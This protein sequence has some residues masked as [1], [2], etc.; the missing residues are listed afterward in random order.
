VVTCWDV[1][2]HARLCFISKTSSQ[3]WEVHTRGSLKL[4]RQLPYH[5]PVCSTKRHLSSMSR[6]YPAAFSSSS[7][8]EAVFNNALKACEVRIKSGLLF[9]PLSAQLQTSDSPGAI[10]LLQQVKGL[11]QS[12]TKDERLTKWLNPTVIVLY[13]LSM[14]LGKCVSRHVFVHMII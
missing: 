2:C 14:A 12:R 1:T 11:S 13:A 9:Y 7:N 6:T 5:H 3:A 8:F 10:L 4:C